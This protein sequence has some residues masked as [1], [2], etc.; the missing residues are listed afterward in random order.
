MLHKYLV[1]EG[2]NFLY[3]KVQKVSFDPEVLELYW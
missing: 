1:K 2:L 3:I